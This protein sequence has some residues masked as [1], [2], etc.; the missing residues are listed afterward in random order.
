MLKITTLFS[1]LLMLNIISAQAPQSDVNA[2]KQMCGCFEASFEY[3]ETFAGAPGYERH[4][5]Y[6]SRG[7]EWIFVEDETEGKIVIQHLLIVRDS[8]IV[9][10]WRQDW[11]YENT[12]LLTY[13]KN[14]EW[15]R[16]TL[17]EEEVRGTWTQKV[18]EVD[19]SPR[20]QG[21]AT[22]VSVDDKL[23]WE[24][25]VAA[26][27]PRREYT[28]RSD[29]NVMI[30]NNK[31][32]ITEDGHVH[33]LDNAKVI[34]GE[35]GDS[36][37]VQEK[38]LNTYRRVAD[39][40]CELAR[41]WWQ[42]HHLFWADVR[43]EW[44]IALAGQDYVNIRWDVAGDRL[45]HRIFALQKKYLSEGAYTSGLASADIREV[46]QLYLSSEPTPWAS[47]ETTPSANY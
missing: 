35:D 42:E 39:S 4:D 12:D 8:M 15:Q 7:L 47:G 43:A 16:E 33:E 37:L 13:R 29:Y 28:K 21:A 6:S 30:R 11:L 18:Y 9:K 3:A 26:P 45:W 46:I 10:H 32:R 14:L 1:L 41:Q 19:E 27:L 20:Y 22:W 34:R 40:Q 31:H 17:S 25:E 24:S 38:G 5:D 2:I 36:I 44:E 23:Y